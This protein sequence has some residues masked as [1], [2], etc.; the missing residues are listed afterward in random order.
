[1][2]YISHLLNDQEMKEVIGR[3][4]GGVES[5]EFSIAQNLDI[6]PRTLWAYEKR[7]DQMGCQELILHGP[8]LDLNPMAYD[9]WVLEATMRRYEEAYLA[10][11]Y[12]GAKK[13][14]F[15][16]CYIPKVYM[17]IGWAQRV[18]DFY[19][20]FLEDKQGIQVVMENVQ[21]PE[22][23]PILEVAE[24][25]KHP[26][27]GLCLDV[28]H[29]NCYSN[30]PVTKWVRTLGP[31]IRHM[32]LHDNKGEWDEHAALGTGNVPM[33]EVIQSA[34]FQNPDITFTLECS[35]REAVETSLKWLGFQDN[36]LKAQ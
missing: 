32:H 23:E 7:L 17:L 36:Y 21:D 12:L 16:T 29:A 5:I 33:L 25:I 19:K 26:D 4:G 31:Y 2:V 6:L 11:Q 10:A 15:H 9:R 20:R 14:V 30:Y 8:F 22:I 1:M 34:Q 18:V 27:F 24:C 3:A 13:I 28:G 35:T